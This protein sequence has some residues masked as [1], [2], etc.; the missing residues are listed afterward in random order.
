MNNNKSK[1]FL[2][3][4][5]IFSILI[6]L[7]G[8]TFS[9]FSISNKSDND[10]LAVNASTVDLKLGITP[11]YVGHKLIPTNDEDIM[12]AYESKCVDIYGF[13]ACLA[14]DVEVSNGSSKQDLI[15][16]IDFSVMGIENLSYM[17]LD[18]NGAVYLEKTPIKGES[19][20]GMSLGKNF[21]LDDAS[22]DNRTIKKFVLIIWLTNLNELQDEYDAG[23]TF[24]ASITYQSVL[25]NKLTGSINGYGEEN[26]EVSKLEGE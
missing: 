14:Y 1:I 3:V 5:S 11:K 16:T 20:V 12:I 9:Y 6:L 7:L 24:S 18:Q 15:G 2:S 10:A 21:V 17:L 8:T 26:G 23:G 22:V 25:G 13:G 4:T 19:T